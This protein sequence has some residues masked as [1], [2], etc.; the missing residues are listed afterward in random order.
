MCKEISSK[1]KVNKK[2]LQLVIASLFLMSSF[3]FG[4]FSPSFL[5][6]PSQTD[7]HKEVLATVDEFQLVNTE[8]KPKHANKVNQLK[9]QAQEKHAEP[10]ITHFK[11]SERH[12]DML[13]EYCF[14]CHDDAIQ[15]G[16]IRLDNLASLALPERLDVFNKMQEQVY[17]KHMP[18]KKK[19]QPT[20]KERDSLFKWVST[21]L[22]KHQASRLAEKISKPHYANYVD[23]EKLFSGEIKVEAFSPAR[24][25]RR[26]P[27]QFNNSIRTVFGVHQNPKAT[28]GELNKINQPF[29]KGGGEGISDYASLFYADSATFDTLHRNAVFIVDSTLLMAF[30]EMDY[31]AQGKTMDDWNADR[32]KVIKKQADVIAQMI[33][34]GKNPRYV[35]G[36][37]GEINRKYRLKTPQ[38][39][40]DIILAD[41]KPTKE[42]MEAAIKYHFERT[43]Q[44]DASQEDL[45]KYTDFMQNGIKDAGPYFGLRNSLIAILCSPKFIYRSELGL[46]KPV[47]DGRTMLSPT[48]LAYAISYALTDQ[49][50][51]QLLLEAAQNGKLTIRED[52]KREVTR[53]LEDSSIDKPRI[54]RFFQEFFGYHHAPHIFKDDKR[55]A[56]GYTFF[57]YAQ[58]YVNDTDVL[59]RH[60]LNEDKN[61]FKKLLTTNEYFVAHSGDNKAVKIEI[62]AYQKMHA[63]F[64]DKNW[65]K[66]ANEL[67][68]E[69]KKFVQ[70][71]HKMFNHFNGNMLKSTMKHMD[72]CEKLGIQSFGDRVKIERSNYLLAYNLPARKWDFPIEQPFVLAKGKRIGILSHPSWLIAHSLNSHTD[73]VRRGKWIREYLLAGTIPDVPITVDATIPE[74]HHQTLR[75]RYSLTEAKQCWK[76]HVKMNP[77][78]YPFE[79]FDDFGKWREKEDMEGLP[80]IKGI[81]V[82]KPINSKGYLDGTGDKKLDGDVKNAYELINRLAESK[83]V[84]QS[85]IRHTFRYWM[86]RNELLTDSKT[87]IRAEKAYMNNDG[88]FKELLIS[89][90]TSDSFI[91]RKRLDLESN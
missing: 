81:F 62:E 26:S 68:K 7:S 46:G 49:K 70:S 32:A 69:H 89:L 24:L 13:S 59:I 65:K 25:W 6:K 83:K 18:P 37:H 41:G 73:P 58:R 79:V 28:I 19:S 77:L 17:L 44:Q 48:E 1:E 5:K 63:F 82:T 57:N 12:D 90:L 60:I 80:K 67:I 23:H 52:V 51:D 54:L 34:D 64:K 55:F 86:G 85:I 38:V 33:K 43:I 16:N 22:D 53:L 31:K 56:K 3:V 84:Q 20:S 47:G 11:M 21:E 30:I 88:S 14:N 36:M 61:V 8:V 87:L 39:Y 66:N 76:C 2:S 78:G 50:P 75:E 40:R 9:A 35:R 4:Y 45:T 27:Y 72:E 42:M 15:K 91:Y 10:V 74:D 71:L 29:N